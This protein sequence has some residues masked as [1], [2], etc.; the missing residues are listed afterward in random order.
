MSITLLPFW[1]IAAPAIAIVIEGLMARGNRNAEPIPHAGPVAY[2]QGT[3]LPA[4][5]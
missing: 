2:P 3:T 1:I 5:V 4:G